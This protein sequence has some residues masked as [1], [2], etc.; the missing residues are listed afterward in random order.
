M[1]KWVVI[2]KTLSVLSFTCAVLSIFNAIFTFSYSSLIMVTIP[3]VLCGMLFLFISDCVK[4]CMNFKEFLIDSEIDLIA[5]T[6]QEINK[7][8]K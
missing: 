6:L 8:I 3:L 1:S 2:F 4:G 7:K 5:P